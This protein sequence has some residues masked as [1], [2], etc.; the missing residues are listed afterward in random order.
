[1]ED[2]LDTNQKLH[3]NCFQI[4]TVGLLPLALNLSYTP[5]RIM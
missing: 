4:R 2:P 1:M 5:T 3:E